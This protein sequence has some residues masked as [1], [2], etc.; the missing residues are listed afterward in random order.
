MKQDKIG[1]IIDKVLRKVIIN[2]F[3]THNFIA[4]LFYEFAT[5]R[6]LTCPEL[7]QGLPAQAP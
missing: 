3:I 6:N 7:T 2:M 1:I 4:L 5:N